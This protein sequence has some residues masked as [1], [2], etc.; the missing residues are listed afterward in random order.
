[1]EEAAAVGRDDAHVEGEGRV[2]EEGEEGE[3]RAALFVDFDNIV[4]SF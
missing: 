4:L 3:L 2:N 1:M